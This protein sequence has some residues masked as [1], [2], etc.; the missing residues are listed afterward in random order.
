MI[1]CA[2]F[3][4]HDLALRS[5]RSYDNPFFVDLRARLTAPNG[6]VTVVRGFYDGDSTWKV[7]LC[8]NQVGT[9]RYVTESPDAA[10]AGRE[11]IIECTPGTNPNVHGALRVD[12]LH[13]HH[14]RYE[15]GTRPFVLGYEANWLWALGFLEDGE[16]QLRRF[17]QRI[18]SYGYNHVFVNTYA[19]DTRW[20]PGKSHPED[21]GPPPMYAWEGTNEAPDHSR[22]NVAYWR[23]FD[24]MMRALFDAGL[25]AHLYLKVYN[26]EVNWPPIASREDDLFFT[27]VVARYGGFSNV[28]WD[29]SKESYN[30]RNKA[31][32]AGRLALI[33][34]LDGY[35]RLVTTHDDWAVHF[36]QRYAGLLD[37]VTDQKHDGLAERAAFLRRALRPCPVI[38]EEFAYECGPGGVEDL[39]YHPR[40]R[41]T[42]EE[43][44]LRAWEVVMGGAYPGYYYLY[45][46]WDVVRPDDLPPGYALHQRLVAFMKET[47]WWLLEPHPEIVDRNSG[48]CLARPLG[49]GL[50]Y[51]IHHNGAPGPR[52]EGQRLTVNFPNLPTGHAV[53]D[54]DWLHPL[55]GER[56]RTQ[57]EV[58]RRT[59]LRPPFEGPY[60][61]R[62]RPA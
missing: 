58:T 29:A 59:Q 2:R 20:A 24:L 18:A 14:F 51:L 38:N 57:L 43:H 17:C 21:Y 10:L 28:V 9:W 13:P 16:A 11:G 22:L 32:L 25:T 42:P 5:D 15:D 62:L 39:S 53:M 36:D 40:A 46:A 27:Y 35:G 1:E 44:V 45:T 61:V 33:R 23:T 12:P 34:A 52:G 41:H 19:H 3:H 60:V 31:Y 6:D 56:T 37:F 7:R 48:R 4:P 47:E 26:K 50:E 8:P 54:A 55:T 49:A 30:E